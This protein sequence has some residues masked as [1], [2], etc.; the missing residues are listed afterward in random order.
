MQHVKENKSKYKIMDDGQPLWTGFVT[1]VGQTST[2]PFFEGIF[3]GHSPSRPLSLNYE[4]VK[5]SPGKINTC[6]YLA[7]LT[8]FEATIWAKY[9]R[10]WQWNKLLK[11]MTLVSRIQIWKSWIKILTMSLSHINATN[12]AIHLPVQVIW[13][14]IWN[15]AMEKSQINATNVTMHPLGHTVWGPT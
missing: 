6:D 5:V 11:I 1:P 9:I 7:N 2:A 13:R 10:E 3:L 4:K 12:A 14:L 15:S 8:Q